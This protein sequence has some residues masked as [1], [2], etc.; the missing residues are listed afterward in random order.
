MGT[1]LWHCGLEIRKFPS[2]FYLGEGKTMSVPE[3]PKYFL[4]FLEIV[5]DSN[6]HTI[7]ELIERLADYLKLSDEGKK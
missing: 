1:P 6:E 3:F 4:P 2:N 5:K 7:N